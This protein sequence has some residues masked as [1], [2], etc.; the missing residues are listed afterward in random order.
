MVRLQYCLYPGFPLGASRTVCLLPRPTPPSLNRTCGFPASGSPP[1]LSPKVFAVAA[2][3][4]L[5]LGLVAQLLSQLRGL[6]GQVAPAPPLFGLEPVS[7]PGLRRGP[8]GQA[9]LPFSDSACN[10]A[11]PLAP[12]ELPRFF[13]TMS[14]SDFRLAPRATLCIP[15]RRCPVAFGTRFAGPP[16]FLDRSIRARRPQP[17]RRA[18]RLRMPVA[19]SS[20]QASP[21]PAGWPL[22]I[23]VTR[24][25]RV[26]VTTARAFASRGFAPDGL[27]HPALVRLHV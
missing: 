9:V 13:A 3:L 15:P 1:L 18:R 27:L 8:F 26:R 22:S 14:W 6:L 24:P 2:T 4:R 21:Y 11:S 10:G 20:A 17:P 23:R 16:R 25:N 19:S 7:R 5:V 12:R